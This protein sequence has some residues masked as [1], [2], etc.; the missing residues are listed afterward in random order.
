[1]LFYSADTIATS[2]QGPKGIPVAGSLDGVD[3]Q[4]L[5]GVDG[6]EQAEAYQLIPLKVFAGKTTSYGEK[7]GTAESAEASRD[8]PQ[9]KTG[10]AVQFGRYVV[11]FPPRGDMSFFY[12]HLIG[13]PAHCS[14]T[15]RSQY[16]LRV[17]GL[18][19]RADF[20]PAARR[21]PSGPIKEM[22]FM[23]LL[24]ALAKRTEARGVFAIS[25]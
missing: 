19:D 18:A 15:G 7:I 8:E 23:G 10:L 17:F 22:I 24:W 16:H 6:I 13:W 20:R 5:S 25:L 3:D 4:A 21:R 2:G 1:M 14:E 12:D 11:E 9:W